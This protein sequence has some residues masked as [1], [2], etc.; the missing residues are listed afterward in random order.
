MIVHTHGQILI[1]RY[2]IL[3]YLCVL[4]ANS[5]GPDQT[6]R[7][8]SL[9]RAFAVRTCTTPLLCT[10]RFIVKHLQM[11][12]M[13]SYGLDLGWYD[14][15]HVTSHVPVPHPAYLPQTN[16][17]SAG[18]LV[19][20]QYQVSQALTWNSLILQ[21]LFNSQVSTSAIKPIFKTTLV[22]G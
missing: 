11:Q 6:A 10:M 17:A 14:Q 19:Y 18:G 5:K 1:F 12:T 16:T 9:I 20:P 4:K 15:N 8:R 22:K 13:A 7:K 2:Y 21:R 3:L